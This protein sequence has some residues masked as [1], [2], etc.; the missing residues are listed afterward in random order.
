MRKLPGLSVAIVAAWVITRNSSTDMHPRLHLVGVAVDL[1]KLDGR[2]LAGQ[3]LKLGGHQLARPAP[4]G[5]AAS[6][7][8]ETHPVVSLSRHRYATLPRDGTGY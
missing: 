6:R 1:E 8:H 5:A 4:C 2:R 7:M 3:L